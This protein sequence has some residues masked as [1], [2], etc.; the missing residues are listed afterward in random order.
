[1]S[2][3]RTIAAASSFSDGAWNISTAVYKQS[4]AHGL[5]ATGL[6][7]KPDGTKMYISDTDSINEYSLST[8]WDV[9]TATSVANS[10]TTTDVTGVF[11]AGD[12][13]NFF[14]SRDGSVDEI[15]KF[16][17]SPAWSASG[18]TVSQT[19]SV[20]TLSPRGVFFKPDGLIMV[21]L[22][23]VPF[24]TPLP[25]IAS[26]ELDAP[27]DLSNVSVLS[28]TNPLASNPRDIFF[29]ADGRKLY[30][31]GGSQIYERN[32][33]TPW[34]FSTLYSVKIVSVGSQTSS[35]QGLFFRPDGK[36][37]Y[38]VGAEVYEYDLG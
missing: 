33:S 23:T 24:V 8:P 28:S 2:I 20:A 26:Y 11:S 21:A 16:T 31:I 38:V 14:V 1:M 12:G 3:A 13:V 35:A 9:T 17:F 19:T 32:L 5:T 29:R 18:A 7:F 10:G 27:F 4:F 15:S 34:S 36:K 22:G 6:T 37:M 25:R 30:E